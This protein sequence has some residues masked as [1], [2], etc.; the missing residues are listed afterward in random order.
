[1]GGKN[2]IPMTDLRE[3]ASELGLKEVKT[4]L[5]SGNLVFRE[6]DR[7]NEELERLLETEV[8]R[9][10][11][12]QADFHVRTQSQIESLIGQNPFPIEAQEDPSHLVVVFFK[13]Q[14][15]TVDCEALRAAI[16]GRERF[17]ALGREAY[18][19]YPDGI[20][21]SKL[22]T[23]LMDSKLRMRGTGRNWNTLL[24]LSE[25]AKSLNV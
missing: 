22:T 19:T 13:S 18:F 24:K 11:N 5:Q 3:V 15:Q 12:V 10:L 21:D 2:K 17:Q 8:H 23:N 25:L 1:M 14:I 16:R 6:S 4:V 9:Q 20:G 7:S